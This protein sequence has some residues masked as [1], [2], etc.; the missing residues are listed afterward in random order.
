MFE[1]QRTVRLHD[2]D[3]AGIL[4]FANYFRMAHTAYESLMKSLG[5]G[6]DY[7]IQSADYMILIVHAEAQYE[8]GVFLGDKLTIQVKTEHIGQTSFILHYDFKD[9]DGNMAATVTV[10]Y[11][12]LRA[13]ET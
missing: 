2:V 10:S 12:H 11:T 7:I 5:C 1:T 4:Y 9:S 6:L 8:S 13:H 3:A